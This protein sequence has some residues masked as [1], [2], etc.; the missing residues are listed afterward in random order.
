MTLITKIQHVCQEI[1]EIKENRIY[2]KPQRTHIKPQA[3]TRIPLHHQNHSNK[4]PSL[5]ALSSSKPDELA[6]KEESRIQ[7]MINDSN[8][9]PKELPQGPQSHPGQAI[10][11]NPNLEKG[12]HNIETSSYIDLKTVNTTLKHQNHPTIIFSEFMDKE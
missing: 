7:T 5:N 11:K 2:Q 1:H 12:V 9:T 4:T 10:L 6:H 8:S 3:S